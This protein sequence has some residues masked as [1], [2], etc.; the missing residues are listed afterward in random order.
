MALSYARQLK[1][2]Y[3]NIKIGITVTNRNNELVQMSAR[4]NQEPNLLVHDF[5]SCW[6][7]RIK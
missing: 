5:V 2:V 3:K 4:S 6:I 1:N 7:K